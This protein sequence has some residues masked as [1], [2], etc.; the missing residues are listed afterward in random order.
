MQ[1]STLS[2]R[3]VAVFAGWSC[4]RR[5]SLRPQQAG[6]TQVWRLPRGS[7][8]KDDGP[9]TYRFTMEYDNADANGDTLLRQR[10]TGEYTRG[11]PGGEGR[12]EQRRAGR[13]N[14]RNRVVLRAKKR[15]FMSAFRYL[16]RLSDTM[17][18]EFFS[19][20]PP[21]AMPER[22]LV[23]D[24]GMIEYLGQEFFDR[25]EL[26]KPFHL[27]AHTVDMP[28]IGT[29]QNRDIVLEWIGDRGETA[30]TARSSTTTHF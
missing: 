6:S 19:K 8:V 17:K 22:N 7:S 30:R 20:F 2:I 15:D 13:S 28:G 12:V 16:N 24:T 4:V 3:F 29:F 21:M 25:L 11:L 5:R 14:R 27:A 26:N 23:W 18:P 9:R 10:L 1:I